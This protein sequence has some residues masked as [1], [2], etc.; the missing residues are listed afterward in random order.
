MKNGGAGPP[1]SGSQ[2]P[3]LG[4]AAEGG[5]GAGPPLYFLMFSC[6]FVIGGWGGESVCETANREIVSFRSCVRASEREI[7][8][9]IV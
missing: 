9:S 3:R 6:D 7:S 8:D 4:P 1:H 2:G 5:G